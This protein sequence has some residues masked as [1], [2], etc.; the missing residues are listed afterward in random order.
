MLVKKF[1][2]EFPELYFQEIMDFISMKKKIL[3]IYVIF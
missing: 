2:G 1:D 3:K